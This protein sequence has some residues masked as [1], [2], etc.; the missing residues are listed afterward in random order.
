MSLLEQGST[1]INR[2]TLIQ[3][4]IK[5]YAWWQLE[6]TVTSPFLAPLGLLFEII[7]INLNFKLYAKYHCDNSLVWS[8]EQNFS[9]YEKSFC[10][11][12]ERQWLWYTYT[13]IQPKQ[14]FVV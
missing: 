4:Q 7:K 3:I 12:T 10:L 11:Q 5:G 13:V 1:Y 14:L 6:T 8:S 9:S 2:K